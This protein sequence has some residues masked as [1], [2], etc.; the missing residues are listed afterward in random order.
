MS[1]D[2]GRR[3]QIEED[4]TQFWMRRRKDCGCGVFSSENERIDG[5]PHKIEISG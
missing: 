1:E 5:S 3:Q 2:K 4:S